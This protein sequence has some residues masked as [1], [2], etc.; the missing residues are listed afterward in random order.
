MTIMCLHD[1][2]MRCFCTGRTAKT[3]TVTERSVPNMS[4]HILN[5]DNY[6]QSRKKRHPKKKKKF[7]S[8]ETLPSNAKEPVS[9]VISYDD[10]SCKNPDSEEK[11]FKRLKTEEDVLFKDQDLYGDIVL[12]ERPGDNVQSILQISADVC[13]MAL[14]WNYSKIEEGW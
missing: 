14:T 4:N 13:G 10:Q 12:W 3:S 8:K 5:T 2:Y 6:T 1:N 9:N 11:S 7:D